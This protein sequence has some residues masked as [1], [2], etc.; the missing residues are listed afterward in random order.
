MV[1]DA[2]G[3]MRS[4]TAAPLAVASASS[5]ADCGTA[6]VRS[7]DD[8]RVVGSLIAAATR[9][10]GEVLRVQALGE[11]TTEL[12]IDDPAGRAELATSTS[13]GRLV[14]PARYEAGERGPATRDRRGR[15][16]DVT[17]DLGRAGA[18]RGGGSA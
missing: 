6:L 18:R 4:L 15:R 13:R 9:P 10:E 7:R 16:G 11:T 2:V 8:A 17:S 14:A 3:W 12:E 5:S 1:R